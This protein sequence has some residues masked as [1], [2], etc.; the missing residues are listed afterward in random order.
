MRSTTAALKE[1]AKIGF[2]PENSVRVSVYDMIK[3]EYDSFTPEVLNSHAYYNGGDESISCISADE[4]GWPV[5]RF[6]PEC[7]DRTLPPSAVQFV[8]MAYKP[9]SKEELDDFY[10][11]NN[12]AYDYVGL[13]VNAIPVEK[14]WELIQKK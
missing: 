3:R 4:K 5:M 7:W 11:D 6:N 12:D 8:S 14:M 1:W 10:K 9:R 13:F 2:V